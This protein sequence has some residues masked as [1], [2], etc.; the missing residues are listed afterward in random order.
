MGIYQYTDPTTGRRHNFEHAGDAPTNEDYAFISDFLRQDREAYAEKYQSVFGKAFE[1]PDDGSAIGRGYE[2]GT[3]QVKQAFGETVGT[4]GEETGLG[5]LEDYGTGLE[6]RARQEQGIL[7]LTQPER[8]QSTDVKGSLSRGATYLGEL[9]GEQIP[10]FG[11]GLGTAVAAPVLAGATGVAA[12]FLIGAGA[13]GVVTAPILF[14]NNIQRQEDEVVAGKKDRVDVSDALVATFGQAALEGVADKLLL[15]GILKPLG[16]NM[17]G[18]KGLLT[19]T[20]G[21][22]TGGATS[23]GLTE[24]GQQM[25]ERSQAGLPI[26]SEDA[27]AEYRE[28]AIAGGLIGGGTRSTIGAFGD[29]PADV[30]PTTTK[31]KEEAAAAAEAQ[32]DAVLADD[33]PADPAELTPAQEAV[34][35]E[36]GPK[37][38]ELIKTA[39][40]KVAEYSAEPDR[41]PTKE[42]K[43]ALEDDLELKTATDKEIRS[44][45]GGRYSSAIAE[46]IIAQRAAKRELDAMGNPE[47]DLKVPTAQEMLDNP[48]VQ[49]KLGLKKSKPRVVTDE[50]L[51]DLGARPRS[52][53]RDSKKKSNLVGKDL[54]DPD[55]KTKLE[56]YAANPDAVKRVPDVKSRVAALVG[57]TDGLGDGTTVG[58][59][60]LGDGTSSGTQRVA[61][62]GRS[63]GASGS[64]P[65]VTAPD[66]GSVGDS[67]PDAEL[68]PAPDVS[69]PDTLKDVSPE[70]V[71][72][73][74]Q[75]VDAVVTEPVPPVQ[76]TPAMQQAAT[77]GQVTSVAQQN[78]P[79]PVV[80]A[81]RVAPAQGSP[82]PR[83]DIRAA[84]TA[85]SDEAQAKL[86]AVFENNRGKQPERR[87]YH[88]TQLDPRDVA[89]VTTAVDKEGIIELLNTKDDALDAQGK[90]AKLYFSRFRR[91]VDALAEIGAIA[92][93]GPTQTVK[94]DYV[95]VQTFFPDGRKKGREPQFAFYNGMTQK[96]AMNARRW[97]HANMS[98]SAIQEMIRARRVAN[99]DTS[100]Y[101]PS[102]AVIG[103]VNAAKSI[104]QGIDREAKKQQSKDVKALAEMER[105]RAANDSLNKRMNERFADS[106]LPREAQTISRRDGTEVVRVTRPVKGKTAFESY[107]IGTGLQIRENKKIPTVGPT[108]K[109][110]YDPE[111]KSVVPTEEILDLYD[112]YVSTRNEFL[113]IDPVHGLDM[114]LL[115][116]IRNALQR[117]DLQFALNA[118]A[119]TS[120]VDRIRAIAAKL[121]E[122]VGTTKVQ[123]MDDISPVAGRTAAGLF[124]PETN[125]IYLDANNG[126]N[127]HTV[128]HEM[129]HAATS[130]SL[131]NKSL[132]TTKQLQ[133]MLDSARE[134]L[135][136][137]YGTQNLDEFV[138]EAQSNPEFRSALAL[139]KM[140]GVSIYSKFVDTMT[141]IMRRI[142]G[143]PSSGNTAQLRELD[144][145][146]EGLLA[147]SPATRAAPS[148]MLMAGT[149]EGATNLLK[150]HITA[151][152]LENRNRY[153]QIR[154][155]VNA[156]V[157]SMA[158]RAVL[159]VQPVNNLARLAKDKIPFANDLNVLID[160]AS[161]A[162]RKSFEPID[163]LHNDYRAYKKANRKGYDSMLA[164]MNRATQDE[165]DPSRPRSTY[166]KYWMSYFDLATEKTVV[167]PFDTEQDRATELKRLNDELAQKYGG[168]KKPRTKAKKAGDPSTEKTAIWDTL[169]KQYKALGKQGQDLFKTTRN[170]GE[171]A[172]DRIIPAIKARIA[173]LGV[174]AASQQTAFEKLA[175]LMHAQGGVIRPYFKLSRDG[176]FRLSYHAP[177]PLRN[178]GIELFTEYYASEKDM[179]QGA[180]NVTQYLEDIGRKSDVSKIETGKRDAKR[181]YGNAPSS[182]FVF[183]VLKTL[184]A[185]GVDQQSIDRI[186]D[187]SLDAIPERSFMQSFRSRKERSKGKRGILGAIGDRT[188]SGM[189]GVD[190]DPATMFR[191]NFRS[192]EKQLTQLEFGA[193]IQG[194]RNK[195]KDGGYFTRTDTADIA[196]K[197]DQIAS[198]AQSPSMKRWSQVATSA[199]FGWTMG[200]NISSALNVMFDIPMAVHPYLAGE[201]GGIKATAAISNATKLFMGSP[202]TKLITVMGVDGKPEVREVQ[203]GKHNKGFDN[204]N[205]DD[206][207]LDP[208]IRRYKT[209]V[210]KAGARG[211]FNQSIDQEHVDLSDS[212][213]VL[214]KMNQVSGF[215]VHHGERF[216]RQI[217]L[218]AAYDLELQKRSG[219]GKKELTQADFDAAADKAMDTAELTLGSTASAGR[220][221]WAQHPVGNVAF[222]FKRFAVSRYY[223]MAHLLD[224]SLAG[225]NPKTR[226]IARTQLAYFMAT[227]GALAGVG[228][229]PLMGAA[230][231]IY[232]MFADDDEDDFEAMMRKLL[233]G[234]VY[235]GLAN[236]LLG[237]DIASRV[238]MNSLLYRQPFID[239]D[240]SA[241]FTLIEQ[242]GGPVVGVALSVERGKDLWVE[243]EVR[244]GLEAMA[245]AVMRNAS[246]AERFFREGSANTLR[247]DP[248]LDDVNPYNS[249][250]QAIGFAPAD[251][252]ENLKINKSE[253]RRQNA[254]DDKR[255][256]LMRQYNMARTEGDAGALRSVREKIREFNNSLP[257]VFR[258]DGVI[259]PK[260]LE[261]SYTGFRTT[262]GKMVNGIT[263]T[264]AMRKSYEEY[265]Q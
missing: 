28:A 173:S 48:L 137:V 140:D 79:A 102:D 257:A 45:M 199:G 35:A 114:A 27:I 204:H 165:V 148:M 124:D 51:A 19:R 177:D 146:V 157:P 121:A 80:P 13:A 226:K 1:A 214:A 217:S 5:F 59:A 77:P 65:A 250:M 208:N 201:Y 241:F 33:V 143:L 30:T 14:G 99:R 150:R 160:Q 55:V 101:N 182:S 53:I 128:L 195:L 211:M 189:P 168:Q 84:E 46:E 221:V 52:T 91:P 85:R 17:T 44:G 259:E 232:D 186:I 245:P 234:T 190:A 22:A 66:A 92:V 193:K 258:A 133:R 9:V 16:K 242:L 231:V 248:I 131:A 181:D 60:G 2:R 225:A 174:D 12:P 42:A 202:S 21:R 196:E 20:T 197:L 158:K 218:M 82:V 97:V 153:E 69:Q 58:P 111:T 164:L 50:M 216:G 49:K 142:L 151:V 253:R 176:D 123:V 224:Q 263:Y 4:L 200:A 188:P 163:V 227:T 212:R 170:M 239:K 261:K 67:V 98:D 185:A 36:E 93:V 147:P 219:G 63:A 243:G 6:E 109:I 40:A 184:Q 54:S 126:M 210:E 159:G 179:M 230:G 32:A 127:V 81:P 94:K 47:F 229:M 132:P 149:K 103:V 96:S 152:P 122:V 205:F 247:G 107:L 26:D 64:T 73:L 3:Q 138:A 86:D 178:G 25:L 87:E 154:D 83:E 68:G 246:K 38:E 264:D 191:D 213:D 187:L 125:T 106:P 43:K 145:I 118:I 135:G 155:F 104:Q 262:T 192:I 141:K 215:L 209:L 207:N 156:N 171:A 235:D 116:S 129:F 252:V 254:V 238:S 70:A 108:A 105:L 78:I 115:P 169:N 31:T 240:Q 95:Q 119:A 194:F 166:S 265:N 233:P 56:A 117:G 7:S 255:K 172:Q 37:A 120:Q 90:A 203:L 249:F 23:E 18:W 183:D 89:E 10:Q 167:R 180:E 15:G 162:L 161:G 75:K 88:D 110:V 244:R 236:E 24:V 134:Q 74:V 237:I 251:Y 260:D 198:F 136:E 220:P 256:K 61:E 228:G 8:M 175:E 71:A 113:L 112:G 41:L 29:R 57:G 76:A 206:P 223:F 144:R 34:V 72:D 222:L 62:L 130:A 139:S 39:K 11:L 100:K